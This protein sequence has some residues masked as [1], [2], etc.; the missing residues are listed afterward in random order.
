MYSL[1][2]TSTQTQHVS[3]IQLQVHTRKNARAGKE[4]FSVASGGGT[5]RTLHPDNMGYMRVQLLTV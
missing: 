4:I 1:Q 5:G 3:S 2:V